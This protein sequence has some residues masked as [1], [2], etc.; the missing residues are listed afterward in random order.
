MVADELSV[1]EV[2]EHLTTKKGNQFLADAQYAAADIGRR[3]E[4]RRG[5]AQKV[6]ALL[7][8]GVD[9]DLVDGAVSAEHL[10]NTMWHLAGLAAQEDEL[11]GDGTEASSVGAH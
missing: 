5:V 2:V 9:G 8:D 4:I 11:A 7:V 1:A 6:T 10:C 3:R